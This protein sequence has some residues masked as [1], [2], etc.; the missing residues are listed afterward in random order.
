MVKG[1][2]ARKMKIL[3]QVVADDEE[4]ARQQE[5]DLRAEEMTTLAET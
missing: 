5:T 3:L 1:D 2:V 4:L